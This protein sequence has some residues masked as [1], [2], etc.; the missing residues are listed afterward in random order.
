MTQEQKIFA[1]LQERPITPLE[2]LQEV[3]C[4]RL[5]SVIH[6]LRGKGHIIR[7]DEVKCP[8][9]GNLF[10]RYTLTR[11]FKHAEPDRRTGPDQ[12]AES[13][14]QRHTL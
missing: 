14:H 8:T 4:F 6:K 10:A 11:E 2:A 7:T 13:N 5:A 1:I 3:G 9:T 12:A